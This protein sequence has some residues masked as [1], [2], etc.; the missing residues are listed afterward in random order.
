MEKIVFTILRVA[1]RAISPKL[2]EVLKNVFVSL[3]QAAAAT[4]NKWD[5]LLVD[6]L[7]VIL[8]IED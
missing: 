5:D 4:D 7:G 3:K 6:V 2:R 8:A 1:V